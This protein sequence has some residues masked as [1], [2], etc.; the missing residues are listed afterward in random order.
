[1]LIKSTTVTAHGHHTVQGV[2]KL[3]V[4]AILVHLR[5]CLYITSMDINIYATNIIVLHDMFFN[6]VPN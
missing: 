6:E 1:M 4:H 3:N 2:M 5:E